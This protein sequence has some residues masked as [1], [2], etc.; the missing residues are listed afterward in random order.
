MVDKPSL[1]YAKWRIDAKVQFAKRGALFIDDLRAMIYDRFG[2]TE[3]EAV[4][5]LYYRLQNFSAYQLI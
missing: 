1:R 4:P 3:N 5:T 2:G